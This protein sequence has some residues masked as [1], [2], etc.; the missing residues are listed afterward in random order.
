MAKPPL[1][2][3]DEKALVQ[4]DPNVGLSGLVRSIALVPAQISLYV[5]AKGSDVLQAIAPKIIPLVVFLSFIPA[6]FFISLSAGWFVWKNVAVG[7]EATM[8]LQYG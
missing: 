2:D 7:W 3:D 8:Y 6:L 5:V 1:S 4:R